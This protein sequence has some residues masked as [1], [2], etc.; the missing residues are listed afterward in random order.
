MAVTQILT[1][2]RIIEGVLANNLVAWLMFED[3][4]NSFNSIHRRKIKQT[5]LA[6]GLPKATDNHDSKDSPNKD[7]YIL[8]IVVILQGDT[9]TQYL[10]IIC[11][12]YVL[13]SSIDLIKEYRKK[14]TIS[15]RNY[16]MQ[17]TQMT[18]HFFLRVRFQLFSLEQ[19]QGGISF[20]V[21][22][23]RIVY[24][25]FK[26]NGTIF[27]VSVKISRQAHIPRQKHL[28]HWK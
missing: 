18:K 13:Q 17:T 15:W 25:C 2:H 16:D 8:D 1:I 6:F 11:R 9:L 12:D 5:L 19:A 4:C 20:Y 23:N 7:T 22:A 24:I 27:I 3:F 10:F 14:Q 28:I 21:T 26:P